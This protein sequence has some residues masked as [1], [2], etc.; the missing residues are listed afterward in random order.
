VTSFDGVMLTISMGNG[1]TLAAPVADD[2][3]IKV[4]HR[5]NKDHAKKPSN[6]TIADLVPGAKV[7]RIK[8]WCQEVVKVRIVR[9]PVSTAPGAVVGLVTT[10]S[11]DATTE[12]GDAAEENPCDRDDDDATAEEGSD[13]PEAGE[14]EGSADG[15]EADDATDDDDDAG[16]TND[17]DDTDDGGLLPGLP[18]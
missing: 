15:S 2:V 14:D 8:V 16:D 17:V 3:Q 13:A 10:A 12:D 9:A 18:L 1:G 7:M 5:S 4:Q 6:G 11:E